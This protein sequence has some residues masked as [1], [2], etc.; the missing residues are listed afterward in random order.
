M[1]VESMERTDER[2]KG[3]LVRAPRMAVGVLFES[4]KLF[5]DFAD[6]VLL[7]PKGTGAALVAC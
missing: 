3:K 2:F 4:P 6:V 5:W 7:G 1:E